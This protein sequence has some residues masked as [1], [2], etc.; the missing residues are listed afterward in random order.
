[1][2][3]SMSTERKT[4]FPNVRMINKEDLEGELSS[5]TTLGKAS[6]GTVFKMK[7][8]GIDVAVKRI[9]G[10]KATQLAINE[11][12]HINLANS[13]KIHNSVLFLLGICIDK[14]SSQALMVSNLVQYRDRSMSLKEMVTEYKDE[15]IGAK[16]I[17]HF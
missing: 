4:L 17:E 12:Y 16:S 8:R 1:M 7:F 13:F 3:T 2:S 11:G 6:F 15:V 10:P 5:K 14:D 9:K